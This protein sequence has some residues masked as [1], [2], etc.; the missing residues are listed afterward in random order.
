MRRIHAR[1]LGFGGLALLIALAPAVVPAVAQQ[2]P[3]AA[4]AAAPSAGEM[5]AAR[6][7]VQANGEAGA[8]NGVLPNLVDGAA[9]GF[10]QTNPDL[11][12]QLRDVAIALRPEYEKRQSEIVDILATAYADHFSEDELKQALAFYKSPVGMKLV[13]DRPM[14]VQQ[15]VQNMQEWGAKL[16]QEVMERIRVEMKK[17]GYDL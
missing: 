16:N 7:L 12:P 6:D 15:A 10:L 5:Q 9:L 8:F 14:I 4:A 17:R 13:K 11:A 3:A 2:P 1:S